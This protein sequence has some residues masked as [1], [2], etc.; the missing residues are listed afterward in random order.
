MARHPADQPTDTELEILNVL[1]DSGPSTVR[2]IHNQVGE[3]KQTN[4]ATTV[5]MLVVM[6]DKGLV[7]R[8]DTV[9]PQ[10]YRAAGTR[11]VAQ[12]KMLKNLIKKAY[13]GSAKSLVMQALSSQNASKADLAEIRE[14]IK[15]LEGK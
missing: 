13:E 15:Q 4:Y 2:E 7:K 12:K 3:K 9:R 5:K 6:F 11:S 8:D 10:V 1:W 14:L